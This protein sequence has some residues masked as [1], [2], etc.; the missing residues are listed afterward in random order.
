[1]SRS[2]RRKLEGLPDCK[3]SGRISLNSKPIVPQ[4]VRRWS[5][6]TRSKSEAFDGFRGGLLR[7][8][9]KREASGSRSRQWK[10]VKFRSPVQIPCEASIGVERRNRIPY[11]ILKIKSPQDLFRP[12]AERRRIRGQDLESTGREMSRRRS[13]HQEF[14]SQPACQQH[15]QN[16]GHNTQ[17]RAGPIAETMERHGGLERH[18]GRGQ[19]TPDRH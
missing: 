7:N 19:S 4:A 17:W 11:S 12:H 8:D 16:A 9:M 3:E 14:R 15:P 5:S 13:S 10:A 1:M 18:G 2:Y 6:C